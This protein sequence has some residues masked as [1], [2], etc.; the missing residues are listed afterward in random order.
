MELNFTETKTKSGVSLWTLS[1]PNFNSVAVGVIVKCGT[2]DEIWPKEA[3]IAHA[4]E[5]MHLQGTKNFPSQLETTEYIEETGGM[6]NA[7]TNNERTF[8]F[9]RVPSNYVERGVQIISEQMQNAIIPENKIPTEMKNVVQEIRKKNDNPQGFLWRISQKFIYGNHPVGRETLGTEESVLAFKQE[10]FL[11]FKKRYYNSS[12]YNFIAVGNITED[13]AM[14]LFDKYFEKSAEEN[15]NARKEEVVIINSNK[16]FVENKE[17]SQLH[18]SLDALTGRGSDKESLYLEFF[19]SMISGGMSFPLFQEVRDKRGLCYSIWAS[20]SKRTDVGSFNIYIGTDPK[21]YKEAINATLEVIKNS[22]SDVNLLNKVKNL[23][24]GKLMLNYE[25]TL[26]IAQWA[27]ND[28]LFLGRPRGFQEI[29]KEIEEVKIEDIERVVDKYLKPEMIYT[30]FLA[31][32]DF[33][34]E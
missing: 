5:H 13:K 30:T 17:L 28:I 2:R 6:I 8:Y 33:K 24:L 18:I 31:P 11:N 29:K 20:F 22:K 7:T 1:S 27:V 15:P 10:D 21:R 34:V 9:I 14:E 19:R 3:G 25:N 4:L 12:N 26:D 16:Q 23:K 32:K